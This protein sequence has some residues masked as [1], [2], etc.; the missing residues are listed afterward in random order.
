MVIRLLLECLNLY[1]CC[2]S[3]DETPGINTFLIISL[4]NFQILQ[5]KSG[6][7]EKHCINTAAS[8]WRVFYYKWYLCFNYSCIT[9]NHNIIIIQKIKVKSRDASVQNEAQADALSWVM[10]V[11]T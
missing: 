10:K 9:V 5:W 1:I 7:I 6:T 4:S 8:K 2:S 3:M 11:Y